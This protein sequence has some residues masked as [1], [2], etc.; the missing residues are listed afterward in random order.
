[1]YLR[2]ESI[3]SDY[4]EYIKF[5]DKVTTYFQCALSTCLISEG[6]CKSKTPPR[7]KSRR[8]RTI[9]E[10]NKTIWANEMD[11]T[12]NKIIVLDLEDLA[13]KGSSETAP[14][15]Q[16]L[17][18]KHLSEIRSFQHESGHLCLTRDVITLSTCMILTFTC[19]A[20]LAF[21]W[22]FWRKSKL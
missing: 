19:S 8:R 12:A 22:N 16:Q 6:A 10:G 17:A 3:L 4:R 13:T 2:Y 11:L 7:C 20:I 5:A 14:K 1:M 9:D 18:L 21:L 15:L